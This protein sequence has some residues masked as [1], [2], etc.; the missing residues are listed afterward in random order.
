MVTR[1]ITL[2]GGSPVGRLISTVAL[3]LLNRILL[4]EPKPIRMTDIKV[5]KLICKEK[6]YCMF[7]SRDERWKSLDKAIDKIRMKYGGKSIKSGYDIS[8]RYM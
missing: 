3:Q 6:Q 8:I 5:S 2:K 7:D 1:Q 4:T